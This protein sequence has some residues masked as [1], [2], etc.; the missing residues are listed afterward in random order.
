MAIQRGGGTAVQRGG[1]D[2]AGLRYSGA[3]VQW[4]GGAVGRLCSGAYVL[5]SNF[6]FMPNKTFE[7]KKRGESF[8]TYQESE[9]Q[10]DSSMR[11]IFF[12]YLIIFC[13]S[14]LVTAGVV[15]KNIG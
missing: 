11:F 14:N 9:H 12:T 15:L 3:A 2:T 7:S 4:G 10:F 1:D 5:E 8:I 6:I 13:G